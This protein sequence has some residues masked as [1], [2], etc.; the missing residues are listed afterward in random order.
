MKPYHHGNLRSALI[1]AA[2]ALAREDGP[3]GVAIREAARRTG[4]SHNA[5]Y[6]HFQDRDEL[7]GE[8]AAISLNALAAAMRRRMNRVSGSDPARRSLDRVAAIGRAYVDYAL[9]EP[10]LFA[11]AFAAAPAAL[12]VG[13]L[14][15]L[16]TALDECVSTGAMPAAKRP[17]AEVSCWSA[18]HGFAMLHLHGPLAGSTKRAREQAL[19]ALLSRMED[20]LTAGAA[21]AGSARA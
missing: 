1:D 16:G 2:V 11:A 6:R 9:K 10:G 14:E 13:P 7:L 15:L 8:V 18:V 12:E 21:R 5:A 19:Q 3:D 20:G 17:G 4:V